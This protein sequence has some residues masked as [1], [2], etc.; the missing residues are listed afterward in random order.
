MSKMS[1]ILLEREFSREKTLKNFVRA[2][3]KVHNGHMAVT[4]KE[5][6]F[7]LQKHPDA[8]ALV[9]EFFVSAQ[10]A[11]MRSD[12]AATKVLRPS[13]VSAR[14]KEFE[15]EKNRQH[16]A[17]TGHNI[18]GAA[19]S[20]L[21]DFLLEVYIKRPEEGD[22]FISATLPKKVLK[23]WTKYDW[24]VARRGLQTIVG[25]RRRR[26][27]LEKFDAELE[28][29][30]AKAKSFDRMV[31]ALD[32]IQVGKKLLGDCTG[33]DLLREAVTLEEIAKSATAQ[34]VFYRQLAA[35]VGKTQTVREADNRAGIV[36]LIT[37]RFKE[38][39]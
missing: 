39:D 35:V 34:S 28:V 33:A 11:E 2:R 12:E 21:S 4:V 15:R 36:G 3:L 1:E 22:D 26:A 7:V 38:E 16:D 20:K 25:S 18:L 24:D 6:V 29:Q 14:V 37:S 30:E 23:S 13:G 32:A 31:M 9:C 10:L 27:E 5:V 19:A 8:Q 17:R